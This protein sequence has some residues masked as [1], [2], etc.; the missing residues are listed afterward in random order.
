MAILAS[1]LVLLPPPSRH[2]LSLS[3]A[4]MTGRAPCPPS[5]YMVSGDLSECKLSLL[6]RDNF[7][8]TISGIS[9]CVCS[10]F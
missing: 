1:Q 9:V 3:E 5:I 8:L 2:L 4:R 10:R 6:L 7:N